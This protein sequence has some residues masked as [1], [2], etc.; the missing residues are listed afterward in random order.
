MS[1][2]KKSTFPLLL[3]C[4]GISSCNLS[5]RTMTQNAT[6][7]SFSYEGHRG[8]RGLYPENSIGAMKVSID[9]PKVTTLEMDCHIT[10]DKKVVVYHDDYI[11]PKFVTYADGQELKGKDVKGTLY[12]YTWEELAKFDL[13]LKGNVEDRKST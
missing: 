7:P 3:I 2:I 8:A 5:K 11:N 13:G 9:L 6:F 1:F 12:S 10:K 4:I